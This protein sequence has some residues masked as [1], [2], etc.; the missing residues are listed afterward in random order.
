MAK[1]ACPVAMA[2]T[3][4]TRPTAQ[5]AAATAPGNM[6]DFYP[7]GPKIKHFRPNRWAEARQG[8][9]Q[10]QGSAGQNQRVTSRPAGVRASSGQEN[11]DVDDQ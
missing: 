5:V 4:T 10:R 2:N 11:D 8:R 7:V 1:T 9:E 6:A 3:P